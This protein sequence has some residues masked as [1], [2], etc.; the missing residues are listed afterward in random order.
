M[1]LT[2]TLNVA[3][4]KRYVVENFT[5]GKVMRVKECNYTAGGKG[6][7][8]SKVATIAGEEVLAT[9]F[10]GG[11]AGGYV[12]Q[13][14]DN[15]N[16]K[17]EFISVEGETRSCIN[18][19]DSNSHSQTEFLEPGI[20]VTKEDTQK[21]IDTYKK[22]IKR[23]SVVTI[24]GSVPRGVDKNIYSTLV[25]LAK[26]QNKP[27]I[28]DTSGELLSNGIASLP[29]MIKPNTDEIASLLKLDKI[30]SID[31]VKS[32]AIKM[33][34]KGIPI[35][36]VSLGK[37]GALVVCDE[38]IYRATTPDIKVVNTVGC[39][40]SMVAAFAVCMSRKLPMQETI[41]LAM[42]IST[43]NALQVETGYYIKK[44]M[45]KIYDLISVQIIK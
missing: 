8:V 7:N 3:I 24:S 39:G 2:V 13:Q 1:I 5:I 11:Y 28:L 12:K 32:A 38:G 29:T 40:D 37:D 9:G 45:K 30:N 35:V 36:V 44:D 31:E 22:L 6:L 23:C 16:I 17:N 20:S 15:L 42:A 43:A 19:Y 4:D 10:I 33:H 27:V 25:A 14:L 18:I 26:E 21:F 34:N 41:K